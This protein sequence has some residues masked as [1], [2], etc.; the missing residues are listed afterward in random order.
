MPNY[1]PKTLNTPPLTLE[2]D[3]DDGGGGGNDDGNAEMLVS[4]EAFLVALETELTRIL[5]DPGRLANV[6]DH[7]KKSST[8]LGVDE[9]IAQ[10]GPE[11]LGLTCYKG[12]GSYSEVA[13]YKQYGAGARLQAG[14]ANGIPFTIVYMLAMSVAIT[15]YGQTIEARKSGFDSA[16]YA[17][18]NWNALEDDPNALRVTF[19]VF[20]VITAKDE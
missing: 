13:N 18:L 9:M 4:P 1:P 11:S 3:N 17:N 14:L 5:L 10:F 8:D 16:R 20:H 12:N 2:E 6:K 15:L 19:N 7:Y